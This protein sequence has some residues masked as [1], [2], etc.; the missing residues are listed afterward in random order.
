MSAKEIDLSGI[1]INSP[2][3]EDICTQNSFI[4]GTMTI[5][6]CVKICSTY[7]FKCAGIK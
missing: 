4:S 3:F 7:G 5:E 2:S 6:M 1:C